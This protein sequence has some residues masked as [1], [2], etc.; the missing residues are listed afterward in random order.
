MSRTPLSGFSSRAIHHGYDPTENHGAL[1]PPMHLAST[2]EWQTCPAICRHWCSIYVAP[3]CTFCMSEFAL[4]QEQFEFMLE[5]A[6]HVHV[7]SEMLFARALMLRVNAV[8][9]GM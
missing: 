4:D 6:L 8:C 7:P 3:P 5:Q 1:T 9:A 2:F